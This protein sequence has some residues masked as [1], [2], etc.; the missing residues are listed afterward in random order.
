MPSISLTLQQILEWLNFPFEVAVCILQLLI[1]NQFTN[2]PQITGKLSKQFDFKEWLQT[3]EKRK[4]RKKKTKKSH[5]EAMAGLYYLGDDPK[6]KA[7][8]MRRNKTIKN[9]ISSRELNRSRSSFIILNF[10]KSRNII[11]SNCGRISERDC[12]KNQETETEHSNGYWN[13]GKSRH[14]WVLDWIPKQLKKLSK[15]V[16]NYDQIFKTIL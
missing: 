1:L 10:K 2:Q 12:C 16:A 3:L 9:P 7:G 5:W 8:I 11:H 14:G 6:F 4:G 13:L 15:L